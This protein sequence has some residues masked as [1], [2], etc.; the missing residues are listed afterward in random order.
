MTRSDLL[1]LNSELLAQL[2]EATSLNESLMTSTGLCTL[3]EENERLSSELAGL[4]ASPRGPELTDSQVALI[5][6][7][8]LS[9]ASELSPAPAVWSCE[10]WLKCLGI[11][12]DVSRAMLARLQARAG[13]PR[14]E[15]KFL[16]ELGR[17]GSEQMLLAMLQEGELLPLLA[18]QVTSSNPF[19]CQNHGVRRALLSRSDLEGSRQSQFRGQRDARSERRGKSREHPPDQPERCALPF[20]GLHPSAFF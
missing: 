4:R 19:A 6:A 10:R 13:D 14:L 18:R 2:K 20:S 7:A 11:E 1:D 5:D 16:C 17:K 15:R 12:R 9:A 8:S 3:R